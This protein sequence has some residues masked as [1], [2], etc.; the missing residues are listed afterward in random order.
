[1]RCWSLDGPAGHQ[2]RPGPGPVLTPD[3]AHL[4]N[5]RFWALGRRRPV[6]PD[7]RGQWDLVG[8]LPGSGVAE[9]VS[10]AQFPAPPGACWV[11][12]SGFM[13][14]PPHTPPLRAQWVA[15]SLHWPNSSRC[16]R[17]SW[18]WPWGWDLLL[19]TIPLAA[20]GKSRGWQA[21]GLTPQASV[22]FPGGPGPGSWAQR[23]AGPAPLLPR[24]PRMRPRLPR[25]VDRAA[26][27]SPAPAVCAGTPSCAATW[28]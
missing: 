28:L 21:A 9:L 14:S 22:S 5:P 6:T 11:M 1:M 24:W 16:G 19:S 8:V 10:P 26:C 12:G 15:S 25:G 18:K 7:A 13:S 2:C 23:T 27:R 3:S 20:R 17:S 4:W